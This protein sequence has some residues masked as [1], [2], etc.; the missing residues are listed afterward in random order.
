MEQQL[1]K[2]W[3]EYVMRPVSRDHQ[4]KEVVAEENPDEDLHQLPT[5]SE[6]GHPP[7]IDIN[8]FINQLPSLSDSF[9]SLRENEDRVN[10]DKPASVVQR[11]SDFL[12]M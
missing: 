12:Q 4:M 5:D 7:A 3:K 6:T 8:K 11:G 9:R 10:G 1:S 2:W